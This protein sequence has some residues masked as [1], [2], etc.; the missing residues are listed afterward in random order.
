M[1]IHLPNS[2]F[3]GKYRSISK[4]FRY[5]KSEL[6]EITAHKEW[7]SIHPVVL[8]MIAS[9][10]LSLKPQDITCEHMEAKSKHYLKK[11]EVI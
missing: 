11:N 7:I 3:L 1:K 4:I 5:F 9:L 2:A 10:G 6:L 8:G